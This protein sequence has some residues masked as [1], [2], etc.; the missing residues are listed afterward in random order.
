MSTNRRIDRRIARLV[1]GVEERRRLLLVF[2]GQYILLQPI[3][4]DIGQRVAGQ[5]GVDHV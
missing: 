2:P 1:A 4:H 3:P 5:A